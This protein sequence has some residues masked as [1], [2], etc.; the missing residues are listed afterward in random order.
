V[1]T[2]LN[3]DPDDVAEDDCETAYFALHNTHYNVM[4]LVDDA[5]ELVERYEYTPYGQRTVYTSSGVND[6][7]AMSPIR[8]SARVEVAGADQPYGLNPFGHQGLHHDE[9]TGNI[10]NRARI[11]SPR[12]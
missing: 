10:N 2:S 5:G 1:Q 3:D 12:L 9:E 7:L 8:M 11:L 6:P 4:A